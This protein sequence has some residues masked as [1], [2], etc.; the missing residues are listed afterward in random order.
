ML[1]TTLLPSLATGLA[2]AL[3]SHGALPGILQDDQGW[4]GV[5]DQEAFAAL[6]ELKDGEAP[7]LF[8]E[9]VEVAGMGAYLSRPQDGESIGAILVIH[10][11]WGLNDHVKHWTDRLATDGYTALAIDLYGGEVLTTPKDA[12]AAMRGVDPMAALKKL[13]AA[14]DYLVD[15]EHGLGAE[16]TGCIGWCFGGGWSLNLAIAVP[17]LD[18]AVMYYGRLVDDAEVLASIQAPLL[19]VFANEDTSI[20]PSAVDAFEEAMEKAGSELELHRFDAAHAFA[21][22]SSARYDAESAGAAW[23]ATRTFLCAKMWPEQDSGQFADGSR[24][25]EVVAP[26]GWSDQGERVMRVASFEVAPDTECYIAALTGTAG[27]TLANFNRWRAQM[28]ADQV[29]DDDVALWPKIPMLGQLVPTMRVDGSFQ[30]M[31]GEVIEDAALLGAICTL[32]DEVLFVKMIGPRAEVEAQGAR[33]AAFC[34]G[35]R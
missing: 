33:F 7:E 28:G 5:L 32:E 15:E 23:L 9:E 4:T 18:A 35:I 27:G 6:H 24:S 26:E 3:A 20:P 31:G 14:H 22:P 17:E 25:M 34:R 11:W 10:E 1:S 13:V 30:G 16:R 19:G 29:G 21:N 2:A 8:G 12:L